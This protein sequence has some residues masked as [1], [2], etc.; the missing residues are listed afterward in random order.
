MSDL[1]VTLLNLRQ[2]ISG[3]GGGGGGGVSPT[4]FALLQSAVAELDLK[5]PRVKNEDTQ[6]ATAGQTVFTLPFPYV[7]GSKCLLVF[8]GA[9]Q[10]DAY[11]ELSSTQIQFNTGRSLGERIKVIDFQ[12]GSDDGS[13]V[14]DTLPSTSFLAGEVPA[15]TIDGTDGTDGNGTF[16]VANPVDYSVTP[17]VFVAGG[18]EILPTM[19]TAAGQVFTIAAPY[20]PTVGEI[21]TIFYKRSP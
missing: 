15:G 19:F 3:L 8:T 10:T 5:T 14:V 18:M 4:D 13:T 11:T 7:M 1:L 16:T 6:I 21:I 17:R 20:K 9:V 12:L 2:N